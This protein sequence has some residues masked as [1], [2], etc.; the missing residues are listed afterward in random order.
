[1]A[2]LHYIDRRHNCSS[3]RNFA[4]RSSNGNMRPA[5]DSFPQTTVGDDRYDIV[6]QGCE[7]ECQ[8][9]TIENN[10]SIPICS[11]VLGHTQSK[12]GIA[13]LD[14]LVLD[15]GYWRAM[16]KSRNILECFNKLA[17]R[18]GET[19]NPEYCLVGYEGPC[20]YH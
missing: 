10:R 8:G 18:G 7:I 16:A 9:C 20:K 11:T 17:C 6:C 13:T 3:L 4:I 14:T 19:G 15:P 2:V 12:G 1:M 5:H